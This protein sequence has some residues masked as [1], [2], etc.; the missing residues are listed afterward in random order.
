MTQRPQSLSIRLSTDGLSFCSYAPA[1]TEPCTYRE[2]AVRPIVSMAA[3]LKDALL[4]EPML[5]E[6]YQRVNVLVQTPRFTILPAE[7]FDRDNVE[8]VY[9]FVFP[10]EVAGGH[11][12]Y[13]LLRRA[14]IALVFALDKNIHQLILDDFP[15]ARFY[16]S[17][18]PLTELFS[19]RSTGVTGKRMFAYVNESSIARRIGLQTRELTLFAF[20]QGRVI[21]VNSYNVR[22]VADCQYYLL[23]L[24]KQL[25]F[26]QCDDT[27]VLIHE[28][29]ISQQL[30]E[31]LSP[32][33]QHVS[34]L[35]KGEDLG[36][37]LTLPDA[38][39]YDLQAL[40]VCGF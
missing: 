12:S 32:Y 39:P 8:N 16:A 2:Y 26:D 31:Q 18:A 24:W 36:G 29:S 23:N 21:L 11:I 17:A 22:G 9:R 30:A 13:N 38:L 28:A 4:H 3:N 14:S 6:E 40:L 7:D 37:R 33:L 20:D 1:A 34:L 27:L 19:E 35:E 15:R 25:G 10:D 5:K